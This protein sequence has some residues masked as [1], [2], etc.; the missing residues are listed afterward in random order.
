MDAFYRTAIHQELYGSALSEKSFEDPLFLLNNFDMFGM[1]LTQRF[2]NGHQLTARIQRAANPI[3]TGASGSRYV[4]LLEYSIPLGVPVSRKTSVGVLWGKIYDAENGRQGVEGVIVRANDLA[5][6]TNKNGE[7]VFNGLQPGPY[8]LTLDE[9][10]ALREKI[11]LEKTPLSVFVEGGKNATYSIGL[12]TG[13]SISG[14]VMVYKLDNPLPNLVVRKDPA[15][16]GPTV[17]G[18]EGK[19]AEGKAAPTAAAGASKMIESAALIATVVELVGPGDAVFH[20]LTDESGRFVFDGLRPGKYT[21]RVFDDDLPELHT[22]DKDTFELDVKPAAREQVE[23]KVVPVVRS[24]QII[25]G[26]EVTIKKKEPG[27]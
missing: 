3:A 23:V 13:A 14:R 7:Y 8:V 4:G 25:G 21:L 11:T 16:H 9:R 26:G 22:F 18:A 24:I 20:A 2:G 17:T 27:K 15:L 19:G 1:S 6:V 12:V 5:T 10:A